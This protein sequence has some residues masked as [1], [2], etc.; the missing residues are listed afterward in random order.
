MDTKRYPRSVV[1]FIL[2]IILSLFLRGTKTVRAGGLCGFDNPP[3]ACGARP[4]NNCSGLTNPSAM[5]QC[6][7]TYNSSLANWYTCVQRECAILL[8]TQMMQTLQAQT[9]PTKEPSPVS[10]ATQIPATATSQ[11]GETPTVQSPS[12]TAVSTN[13]GFPA[14]R[15][16]LV[17]FQGPV[18]AVINGQERRVEVGDVLPEGTTLIVPENSMAFLVA[19]EICEV[20]VEENST[21]LL[22]ALE[23]DKWE[24]HLDLGEIH[25]LIRSLPEDATYEVH[26]PQ[27]VTSVRGTE[28]S[29]LVTEDGTTVKV[30]QGF[31]WVTDVL[32]NDVGMFGPD[33]NA[34]VPT[35]I[36]TV[37]TLSH[38]IKPYGIILI[39][40]GIMV[41]GVCIILFLKL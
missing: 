1:I 21:L 13:P 41:V 18:V 11:R 32:G 23:P 30:T 22:T 24:L 6:M 26:T 2:S 17:D 29:V 9:V 39:L 28:F 33:M 16:L 31:V 20:T 37:D 8:P 4:V 40:G 7:A 12:S 25:N 15:M 38:E 34:F 19:P 10:T 36:P 35:N 14:G 27:A 5:V 3:P